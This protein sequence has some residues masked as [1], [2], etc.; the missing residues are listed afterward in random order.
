MSKIVFDRVPFSNSTVFKLC[1]QIISCFRVNERPI[2][3]NFTS[4]LNLADL[5]FFIGWFFW[6]GKNHLLLRRSLHNHRDRSKERNF[7]VYLSTTL[8]PPPQK[9]NNFP[10]QKDIDFPPQEYMCRNITEVFKSP[11]CRHTFR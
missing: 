10:L 2:C 7:T 8:N 3:K 1:R 4:F 11:R 9:E 6:K 5:P